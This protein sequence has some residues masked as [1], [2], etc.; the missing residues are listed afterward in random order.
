MW[1]RGKQKRVSLNTK[2]VVITTLLLIVTGSLLIALLEWDRTFHTFTLKEKIFSAI[3]QSVTARTAGFNTIP[4]STLSSESVLVL[5]SLMFIGASSGSCGGG[6][7][8]NTFATLFFFLKSALSKAEKTTAFSK[9]FPEDVVRRALVVFMG[10]IFLVFTGTFLVLVIDGGRLNFIDIIFEVI[11]AF[12]TVGLSRGITT[13]L[14]NSSLLVLTVLMFLGRVGLLN[15][16]FSVRRT[17][18]PKIE[19]PEEPVLIG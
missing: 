16:A 2:I 12:G 17:S 9:S 8:T 14:S 4:I 1:L 18:A 6:I 15:I 5:M 3:F 7:K 11:S 19:Y 10:A 13:S